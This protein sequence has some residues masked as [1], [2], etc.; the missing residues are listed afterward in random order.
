MTSAGLRCASFIKTRM[1]CVLAALVLTTMSS[2]IEVFAGGQFHGT[3]PALL[4]AGT[5]ASAAYR[6]M[7]GAVGRDALYMRSQ[8]DTSRSRLCRSRR[9]ALSAAGGSYRAPGCRTPSRYTTRPPCGRD[10]LPL[11]YARQVAELGM[12]ACDHRLSDGSSP[13][14]RAA[15]DGKKRTAAR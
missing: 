7:T 13:A 8:R 14:G 3:V 9:Q 2:S 6:L 4:R 11:A 1:F 12:Y 5:I 15:A 10:F